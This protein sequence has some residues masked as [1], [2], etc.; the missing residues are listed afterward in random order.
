[1]DVFA[2]AHGTT[3]SLCAVLQ[4]RQMMQDGLSWTMCDMEKCM[5]TISRGLFR[6]SP[7]KLPG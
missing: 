4:G 7:V 3:A 2:Q 1:M 6:V 5:K